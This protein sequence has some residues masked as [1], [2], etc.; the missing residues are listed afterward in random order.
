MAYKKHSSLSTVA[1]KILVFLVQYWIKT[2]INFAS[3]R[4]FLTMNES[5][6]GRFLPRCM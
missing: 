4:E 5:S 3:L 6:F 2:L 1:V